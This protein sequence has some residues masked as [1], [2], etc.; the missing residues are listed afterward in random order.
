MLTKNIDVPDGLANTAIGTL[1][2]FILSQPASDHPDFSSYRP[3][4]PWSILMGKELEGGEDK[5]SNT[6]YQMK[7][8]YIEMLAKREFQQKQHTF[9]WC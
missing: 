6:L 1:K 5:N 4:T 7:C 9:L 2:G 3:K 8:Q